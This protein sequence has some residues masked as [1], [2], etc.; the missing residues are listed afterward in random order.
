MDNLIN[1]YEDEWA[2]V[3]KGLSIFNIKK[4][5]SF[6]LFINVSQKTTMQILRNANNSDNLLTHQNDGHKLKLLRSE[7]SRD[8]LIG[9]ML[10]LL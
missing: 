4:K 7:A 3:V 5:K 8:P 2:S 9:L 1:T 6:Y 10:L